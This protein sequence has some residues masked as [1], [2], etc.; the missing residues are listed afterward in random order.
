[1]IHF[2]IFVLALMVSV[3]HA[4]PAPVPVPVLVSMPGLMVCYCHRMFGEE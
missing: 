3:S 2:T 1:M 4:A